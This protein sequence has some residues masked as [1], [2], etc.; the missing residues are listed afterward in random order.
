MAADPMDPWKNLGDSAHIFGVGGI[1][2][3]LGA[4]AMSL[5]KRDGWLRSLARQFLGPIVGGFAALAVF[6]YV[7][8]APV[9]AILVS[10]ACGALGE[11][12]IRMIDERP[13][14]LPIIGKYFEPSKPPPDARP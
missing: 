4:L 12:I 6:S 10:A 8:T 3:F 9:A 13:S 2:G 1:S 14:S 11:R 7:S 5:T